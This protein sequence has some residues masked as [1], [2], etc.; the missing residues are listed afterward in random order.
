[1]KFSWFFAKKIAWNSQETPSLSKKI[2][3]IGQIAVALGVVISIITLST[4]IGAKKEI[5]EKLADFNGHITIRPY[6]TNLSL[7]SDPIALPQDYYPKFP[8]KDIQH[9]QAFGVKSGIIRTKESFDGVLLKGIDGNF[10]TKRFKKFLISGEIPKFNSTDLI[11]DVLISEKLS[12]RFF[13]DIDSTFNMVFIN[14]KKLDSQP[15]YRKF[16][17]AGI[18]KTDISEFDDLFVIGD[19][20]HVQKLN[21]WGKKYVG[22][23]ELF[24]NDINSDLG[25]IKSEINEIITYDQIA[26]TAIDRFPEINDWITIF[27]TNIFIILFIMITVVIINMVMVLLIL[28]L[29]RTHTIGILK[30]MGAN[31]RVIM[32]IFSNQTVFIMLPGLIIGNLIALFLLFIQDYYGIVQLPPENYFISKAPVY[33]SW[34]IFLYVNIIVILTTWTI[35]LIPSILI[36]KISPS[37]AIKITG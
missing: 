1:M 12:S 27:D 28:I 21:G 35:L 25:A 32:Q 22:G 33:L 11:N 36:K 16:R 3:R 10:D 31:N 34:E 30:T 9:I 14:E 24:V 26:E 20:R 29:E 6:N 18:Y 19:I 5:K 4:G 15:L 13:L 37:K 7:N 2:V 8:N 17:V 23:F